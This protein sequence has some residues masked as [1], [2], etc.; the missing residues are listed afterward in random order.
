MS[1][2]ALNQRHRDQTVPRLQRRARQLTLRA[3]CDPDPQRAQR[4]LEQARA[5]RQEHHLR[6][7]TYADQPLTFRHGR[8][9]LQLR[10]GELYAISASGRLAP[11]P[12]DHPALSHLRTMLLTAQR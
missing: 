8:R 10:D 2:E 9:L 4:L 3:L 7:D 12:G 5:L 6:N 1:D 11:R